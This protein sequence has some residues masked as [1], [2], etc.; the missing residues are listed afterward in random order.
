MVTK[1]V[2]IDIHHTTTTMKTRIKPFLLKRRKTA[3]GLFPVYIRITQRGSYSLYSA[4]IYINKSKHWNNK[5][6]Y[7]LRNWIKDHPSADAWNNKI[8]QIWKDIERIIDENPGIHRKQI[9]KKLNDEEEAGSS[10]FI[11]FAEKY[12]TDIE[13]AGKYHQ[14][15]HFNVLLNKIKDFVRSEGKNPGEIR[16]SDIDLKFVEGLKKWMEADQYDSDGNVKWKANHPNTISKEMSRL[17]ALLKE[18]IKKENMRSNPFDDPNY[19]QVKT[20]QTKKKALSIDQIEEIEALDLEE[21]SSLWHVRNYFMFSFWNAGIRFSDL[22]RLKWENI[23]DGRL[24]YTMGKNDKEKNIQ[25]TEPANE[26]LDHYK[27]HPDSIENFIFPIIQQ[28]GLT[29]LGLRKK[30]GSANAIVNRDLK[31]LQRLAS[32]D[33]NI[34][35][36]LSRHSY[37]RWAKAKGLS[38]DFIG[39]QLAH[40]DRSTTEQYLAGLNEY[41]ADD[42]H[43]NLVNSRGKK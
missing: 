23:K 42:E 15:K 37:A 1:Q 11:Q 36:H 19:E 25:L 35:F 7:A 34:T 32:I 22:A 40:S 9:V 41:F 30:A 33:T 39:K 5:G 6:S 38:L 8:F 29:Q 16:F 3:N 13:E 18:A 10:E 14:H 12:I 26:I 17:K 4:E 20:V 21:G 43:Q 27:D 31:Q 24:I 2:T 28:K